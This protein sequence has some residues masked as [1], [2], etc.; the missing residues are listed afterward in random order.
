MRPVS[1]TNN[2]SHSRPRASRH[3]SAV[4]R[5]VILV[6]V[7]T[8]ALLGI[9][10]TTAPA[11]AVSIQRI[12][13]QLSLVKVYSPA[14]KRTVVNQVLRPR[15]GG[16]APVF[17]LL[18]GRS[19]GTDGDSWLRMTQ[20]RSFFKN[21][22]VTVVSPLG[23]G[24]EYYSAGAWERYLRF[25]LPQAIKGPLNTTG[26]AA[27]A[28]LSHTA[29][30]ALDLAGR[31]G[32]LYQAVAA[33][34]GCPS[35]SS[36]IG[37]VAI[38]ATMAFGGGNAWSILGPPGSP[39]W[40]DHDPSLHPRRLAGKAVYLGAGS[41]IAG[42]ADGR[43]AGPGLYVG[44]SQVEA[45]TAVCT[46]HMSNVLNGAGVKNTLNIMPTGAHTWVLFE[47]LMRDSWPMI[48]RAIGA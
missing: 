13:S 17:Y 14:L 15:G 2:N 26:R 12:D 24:Y 42:A 5:A 23:G 16:P 3:R 44:P 48:A 29:P 45:I 20:Y 32:R 38:P 4:T 27:V 18:N 47:N 35:I 43:A 19:G 28:G 31:S 37:Q 46:T 34:S 11:H 7:S 10:A 6:V 1:R 36:P 21:K 41:G 8:M 30:A 9:Q 25:E 22:N 39:T 40:A 33:Y